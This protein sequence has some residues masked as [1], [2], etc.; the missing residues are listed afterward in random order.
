MN[1]APPTDPRAWLLVDLTYGDAAKG[2]TVDY[3]ARAESARTVVR[4]NGGPQAGHNVVTPDRRHHTFSQFGSASF[5]PGVLTYLSRHVLIN[6]LNAFS[7]AAHLRAVGVPDAL[8]RLV[9]HP[10]SLVITPFHVATNRLRE[11]ARGANRHGSCGMGIGE[12]VSH[13]LAFPEEALR[14][15]DLSS[16]LALRRKLGAIRERLQAAVSDLLPPISAGDDGDGAREHLLTFSEPEVI[17]RFVECALAYAARITYGDEG[18]LGTRMAT[19]VTVFESAQ[20]TLIDEDHG[21]HPHTTWSRTALANAE[22]LLIAAGFEGEVV[23]LGLVRAYATRHGAGPFVTEDGALTAQLPDR[24]NPPGAWQG[25]MRCGAFDAVATRYA[26]AVN[27][28]LDLLSVSHL[29]ALDGFARGWPFVRR[30]HHRGP[31]EHE[32]A[33][34]DTSGAIADLRPA[35]VPPDLVHQERLT[36]LLFK[37]TGIVEHVAPTDALGIIEQ[38]TGLSVALRAHGPT[39][40]DRTFIHP[41]ARSTLRSR[42]TTPIALER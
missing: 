10:D 2:A 35:S 37:S 11:L 41:R 9:V 38:E 34:Y 36:N 33:T 21:F 17:N 25:A 7:E 3:L 22:E 29:D 26:L 16:P 19:G 15:R 24:F 12:T 28:K 42:T 27:P 14:A 20:G 32:L 18:W 4:F 40:T 6:P 31:A 1:P 13:S 5:L 30:Y 23:R 8:D 39:A